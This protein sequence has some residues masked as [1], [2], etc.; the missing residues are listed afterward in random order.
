[1]FKFQVNDMTCGHCAST[2]DKAVKSLDAEAQITIDLPAHRVEIRSEKPA[3][4]F[5]AAT[6]NAGSAGTLQA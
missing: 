6:A 2:I 3:S 5:A 1:M 4:L